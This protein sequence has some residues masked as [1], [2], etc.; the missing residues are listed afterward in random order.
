[1]VCWEMLKDGVCLCGSE[2][3]GM[4]SVVLGQILPSVHPGGEPSLAEEKPHLLRRAGPGGCSWDLWSFWCCLR[5]DFLQGGPLGPPWAV[6]TALQGVD[7]LPQE[8]AARPGE[9]C[10][11]L[12]LLS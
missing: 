7:G 10:F 9:L 5:L 12:L 8:G 2:G 6:A 11:L 4:G 3:K 1:M